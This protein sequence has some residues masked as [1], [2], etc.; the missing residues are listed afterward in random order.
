M[1]N[2]AWLER[3][4][5]SRE[6]FNRHLELGRLGVAWEERFLDHSLRE[7][8]ERSCARTRRKREEIALVEVLT[9]RLVVEPRVEKYAWHVLLFSSF[10]WDHR[11]LRRRPATGGPGRLGGFW[12]H[13]LIRAVRHRLAFG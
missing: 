6:L 11:S 7:L 10:V 1:V 9:P 5:H 4:E 2:E 8:D 3:A 12:I 13:R